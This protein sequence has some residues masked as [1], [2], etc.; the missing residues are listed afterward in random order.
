MCL[1]SS[2]MSSQ[3]HRWANIGSGLDKN[4]C[5]LKVGN[6]RSWQNGSSFQTIPPNMCLSPFRETFAKT[7]IVLNCPQ[8]N[9]QCLKP[10]SWDW[11]NNNLRLTTCSSV[12]LNRQKHFL[13]KSIFFYP[14]PEQ[15]SLINYYTKLV[16]PSA[17]GKSG[18][19]RTIF[20]DLKNLKP[21]KKMSYS[22][23]KTKS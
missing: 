19:A 6:L 8:K 10:S 13:S 17:G 11:K 4:W 14:S 23:A 21:A 5:Q 9:H 18:D 12:A 3:L 22:R 15:T 20:N 16:A 2:N 7:R 1:L